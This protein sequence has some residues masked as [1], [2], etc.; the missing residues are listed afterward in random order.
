MGKLVAKQNLPQ[1]RKWL[2]SEDKQRAAIVRRQKRG[3]LSS[4][5]E[6]EVTGTQLVIFIT[7]VLTVAY[8]AGLLPGG[9]GR[10]R[11]GPGRAI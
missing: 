8:F 7:A 2:T 4:E 11:R 10:R 3:N 9:K 5:P 6:F 1:D